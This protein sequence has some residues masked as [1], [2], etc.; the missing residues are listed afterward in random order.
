MKRKMKKP[1]A[2]SSR[3]VISTPERLIEFEFIHRGERKKTIARTQT[4]VRTQEKNQL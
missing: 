1:F 3:W 4:I 2:V